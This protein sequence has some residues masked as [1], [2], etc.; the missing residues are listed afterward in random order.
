M[1]A[2]DQGMLLLIGL[3]IFVVLVL[4]VV[5]NRLRMWSDRLHERAEEAKYQQQVE[6]ERALSRKRI[7]FLNNLSEALSMAEKDLRAKEAA[8]KAEAKKAEKTPSRPRRTSCVNCGAPYEDGAFCGYC[9]T[10]K[11]I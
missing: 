8:E 1:S 4:Q 5:K 10:R 2:N 6:R 7:S 11:E 3:V 9:G